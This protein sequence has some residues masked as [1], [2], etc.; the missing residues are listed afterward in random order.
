[1][2]IWSNR[3]L[4]LSYWPG[5]RSLVRRNSVEAERTQLEVGDLILDLLGRQATR[6]WCT[7]RVAG[8]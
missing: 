7:D 5:L 2:I 8:A 1:M 3:L 4:F 6:G